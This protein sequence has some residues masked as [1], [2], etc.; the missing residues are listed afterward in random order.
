[1]ERRCRNDKLIMCVNLKKKTKN[2][3]V[4]IPWAVNT[5]SNPQNALQQRFFCLVVVVV[6][7]P[8]EKSTTQNSFCDSHFENSFFLCVCAF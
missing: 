6:A 2:W 1:M 4:I 7:D 8:A 3:C 5:D